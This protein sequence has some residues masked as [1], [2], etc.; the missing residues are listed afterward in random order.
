MIARTTALHYKL[1][2]KDI[3]QIGRELAVDYVVEGSVRRTDERIAATVQLVE[4]RNQ[5][6]LWANRYDADW[7]EVLNVWEAVAREIAERLGIGPRPAMRKPTADLQAYTLYLQGRHEGLNMTPGSML[8]AKQFFDEAIE[9][10]HSFALA[11]DALG[12]LHW[13][14]G[15]LGV[16]PPRQASSIGVL[17]AMRALEL[18]NTLAETHALLGWFRKELDYDW[19]EVHREMSRALELNPASPVVRYRYAKGWLCP[20]GRVLEAATEIEAAL[21]LDPLS[22]DMRFWLAVMFWLG[23]DYDRAI[24]EARRML[25]LDRT[26]PPGH[27]IMAMC[28]RDMGQFEEAIAA[29][30]AAVELSGC[31]PVALACLGF[32]LAQR[33]NVADP[34]AMLEQLRLTAQKAYVPPTSLA[35]IHLGLG[36][37]DDAFTWMDRAIDVRD[38]MMTPIK[39][40]PF[41]DPFRSDPRSVRLLAKMN[42]AAEW[43]GRGSW[44]GDSPNHGFC[45]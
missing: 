39:T 6:H 44:C 20:Q 33:G 5:T 11:Y 36:E 4:V 30:R 18:D 10:D 35:W 38:H 29:G 2:P 13:Y 24:E 41:L 12:E 40:Y 45:P 16:M 22:M 7:R 28:F 23:R 31:N 9:R 37:I 21:E 26:Y 14:L 32:A 43:A 34:R 1:R 19:P 3:A 42:L 27:Y 25:E 15:F 8:K 17:A